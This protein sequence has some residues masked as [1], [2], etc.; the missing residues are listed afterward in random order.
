MK[1]PPTLV[2]RSLLGGSAAL[3][4]YSLWR[5]GS[6]EAE[7]VA[8]IPPGG[9]W[10]IELFTSQ[11]CSSCP[12][13]DA[14]L[15]TISAQ[16]NL[17]ALSYHVD[18]WDHIGWKD[19]FAD[20][21]STERQRGYARRLRQRSVYTPEMVVEGLGH[22]PGQ[23]A[24]P[25]QSLLATSAARAQ[26]RATPQITL[27]KDGGVS[28]A[29]DALDLAGAPAEIAMALYDRR[30]ETR[31]QRGEN[32]GRTLVHANVVRSFRSLGSWDGTS[33]RVRLPLPRLEAGQGVAVLVQEADFGPVLGA[34]KLERA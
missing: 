5:A 29:L 17:V 6:A 13:S 28:V 22:N 10:T 31:V 27:D 20:R 3:A 15:A 1:L 21:A 26:R 23:T 16:P 12:P 18:Y 34:N 33:H 7:P 2:R 11:G 4:A 8:V 25:I 30:R 9:P 32:G 19:P 24:E 14:H